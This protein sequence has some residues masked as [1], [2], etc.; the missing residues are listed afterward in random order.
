MFLSGG[1]LTTCATQA[2]P[3]DWALYSSRN[4][5]A[6]F[7]TAPIILSGIGVLFSHKWQ[8]TLIQLN[9]PAPLR[10]RGGGGDSGVRAEPRARDT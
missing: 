4:A 2:P 1:R 7:S 5:A 10:T 9:H 6:V 8:L 3:D